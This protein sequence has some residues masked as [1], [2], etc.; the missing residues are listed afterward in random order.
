M[1]QQQ[2]MIALAVLVVAVA[3]YMYMKR[4]KAK[5]AFSGPGTN[6]CLAF[7]DA[8]SRAQCA[9][10]VSSCGAVANPSASDPALV[11]DALGRCV[12]DITQMD[13]RAVAKVASAAGCLPNGVAGARAQMAASL[14]DTAAAVPALIDW[15]SEAASYMPVCPRAA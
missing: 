10:A 12:K 2:W 11:V 4:Q 1:T 6:P 8:A 3:A 7:P 14:H 5:D 9:R 15:A 13:P